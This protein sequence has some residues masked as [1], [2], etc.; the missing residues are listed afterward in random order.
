MDG[1]GILQEIVNEHDLTCTTMAHI[2]AFLSGV[3]RHAKRQG[4]LN[5]SNPIRD[6]VLP[7]ARRAGETHAYSLA[8][9]QQMPNVLPE[10]AATVV[11]PA[12]FLV[13]E[14]ELR[15]LLWEN[16]DGE[17]IRITQSVWR[18]RIQA[19]KT[20]K[21]MAPV[22][23][24]GVLAQRLNLHRALHGN[25]G[26]GLIFA[27]AA[28]KPLNLDALARDVIRPVFAK[29][30]L[31]WHWVACLSSRSRDESASAWRF[32]PNDPGNPAP[33]ECGG[34]AGL[35]HQDGGGRCRCCN[36]FS[37]VC[38]YC[39]TRGHAKAARELKHG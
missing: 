27:S 18:S 23:I 10:P 29:A 39:S 12:A 37:R 32:R 20:A 15:G 36:A 24:I 26:T 31:R 22:P 8:E 16:Y 14:G 6:V 25:P 34:H 1:E 5:S 35:L 2:K 13:R 30:N 17:Q 33:L 3:F 4:V 11:A 9:I 19:P 38:N 21:S 7:K 28:N